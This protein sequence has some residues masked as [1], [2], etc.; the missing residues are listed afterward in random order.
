M[1][2]LIGGEGPVDIGWM[3][4]GDWIK[5]ARLYHA[6][7]LQLEHRYYGHSHPTADTST[8]NLQWLSSTQ[9]L[10]DLANFISTMKIN[11]K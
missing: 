5:N 2:V 7:T 6:M 10:A 1:F 4:Y 3:V 8:R 9:A 11:L